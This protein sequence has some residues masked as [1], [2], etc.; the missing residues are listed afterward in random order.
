MTR[1]AMGW[2]G[3]AA[4]I[5]ISQACSDTKEG[6]VMGNPNGNTPVLTPEQI[7]ACLPGAVATDSTDSDADGLTDEEET[8]NYGTA[9]NQ[10]DT[11]GDG[12]T[13][14]GEIGIGTNP[15]DPNSTINDRDFF[16]VLPFEEAP[17]ERKL[18]FSTNIKIADVYF[19]VD[20]TSSMQPAITN[21][22]TSLATI[23]A[24]VGSQIPDVEMGVGYFQDFPFT[25][26]DPRTVAVDP[27]FPYGSL[28]PYGAAGDVPYANVRT[29][30]S[31][32]AT[33]L[34]QV[35]QALAGITIGDGGYTPESQVEALYQVAS[36]LGGSWTSNYNQSTF[37]LA[38]RNCPANTRGYPCFRQ[39]AVP[40]V[41]MVTDGPWHN[42]TYP[43]LSY[44]DITPLPRSFTQTRDA[45]NAIGARLIT[46]LVSDHPKAY[47]AQGRVDAEAMANAT[48]TKDAAGT[49][50]VY[51]APAGQVSNNIVTGIQT[52][53]GNVPQEVG[54]STVNGSGNPDDFDARQFI[55]SVTPFEGYAAN[56]SAGQ[57]YQS[58]DAAKFYGV[59]PNS[60]VEFAVDF[61]N[62]VLRHD[63]RAKIFRAQIQVVG[64]GG[65]VLDT[66][67]AYIVVPP[68]NDP[69]FSS[70]APGTLI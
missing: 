15:L 67:T 7:A 46:V 33:E 50:L 34:P 70:P 35:Q 45:L 10:P 8:T 66:R 51:T 42:G 60:Q 56:G 4:L 52:L 3:I 20:A 12:V 64:P 36:G 63:V 26:R 2:T 44:T 31:D 32:L 48:G 21:V 40:I 1:W 17:Q 41:V 49:P 47:P 30:T 55:T 68:C 16:V 5:L 53:A 18:R 43:L 37:S 39:E 61:Q 57:G 58:K 25:A 23:A 38:A 19:L 6:Q 27:T 22:R 65:A 59:L 62:N 24:Q 28:I 11:D 13:D 9:V 14:F 29:M 69:N 54:T